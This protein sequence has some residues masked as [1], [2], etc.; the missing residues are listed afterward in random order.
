MT[1]RQA[2]R[3]GAAGGISRGVKAAASVA[4]AVLLAG[5]LAACTG[6]NPLAAQYKE[7]SNKGFVAADGFQTKEIAPADRG[8][9]VTFTGTT[10]AGK[11]VA[12]GDYAGDVLVVNF[13]YASCG[14]CRAEA[15]RLDKAVSDLSGKKVSFLGVNIRD[16][17]ETSQAFAQTYKVSYPSIIAVNDGQV[18]FDF[19]KATPLTST[20]ITIVLDQKGRVAARIIGELPEPSILTTIVNTVL[21][22]NS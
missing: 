7:G 21:S 17:A 3:S 12:S 22:E 4:L 14:P 5:G 20:P 13:W 18:K 8:D 16:Q 10:D 11:T 6:D 9:A 1:L 19:S 15:P 2:Q